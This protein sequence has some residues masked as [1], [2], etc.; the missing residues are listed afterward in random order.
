MDKTVCVSSPFVQ[1]ALSG[2]SSADEPGRSVLCGGSRLRRE[3][4]GNAIIG[5]KSLQPY[6]RGLEST[7]G[8]VAEAGERSIWE[9][10]AYPQPGANLPTPPPAVPPPDAFRPSPSVFGGTGVGAV[11]GGAA[12]YSYL[13]DLQPSAGRPAPSDNR[14]RIWLSVPADAQ[15]WFDGEPTKQT[16]ELRHF[17]SPPLA[18]GRSYTYDVRVRWTKDGKPVEEERR[19]RVRA[20][21]SSWSDF[22]QSRGGNGAGRSRASWPTRF[23]VPK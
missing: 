5:G 22:T 18:P 12:R 21:A 15:V 7:I 19:V 1:G 10:S 14:A 3:D 6:L 13:N 11:G 20:G 4:G 16:G 9:R 17:V 8:V 2:S 23:P